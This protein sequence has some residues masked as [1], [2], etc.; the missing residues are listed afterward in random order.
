MIFLIE[1]LAGQFIAVG[2]SEQEAKINFTSSFP[3]QKIRTIT[4]QN[5]KAIHIR[6]VG[7]LS[8]D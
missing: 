7:F 5:G 2:A 8:E 4:L 3:N 6:G 1:T